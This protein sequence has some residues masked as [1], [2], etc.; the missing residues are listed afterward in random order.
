[1]E[2][3]IDIK[4]GCKCGGELRMAHPVLEEFWPMKLT[5]GECGTEYK[6]S[7]AEKADK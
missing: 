1:M 7:K 2:E 5:C 3:H 6:V 4:I